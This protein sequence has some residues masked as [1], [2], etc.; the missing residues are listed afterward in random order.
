MGA[1]PQASAIPGRAV[2]RTYQLTFGNAWLSIARYNPGMPNSNAVAIFSIDP[3]GTTGCATA[4]I[5]LRQPTVAR[6]M[7]RAKRKGLIRTW[8]LKG[9]PIEQAWA[10]SRS[11]AD[12]FFFVHI[13][14]SL[15]QSGRAYIVMENFELRTLA[16]DLAPVQIKA[17]VETLLSGAYGIDGKWKEEGFYTTQMPSEMTF[18]SDDMLRKWGLMKGRSPHERAALKHMARRIDRFLSKGV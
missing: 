14:R 12:Y 10:I 9:D 7:M 13:E 3:G 2:L 15:I 18:C 6:C 8:N 5:D 16:A 17:G 4:L 11:V 1:R